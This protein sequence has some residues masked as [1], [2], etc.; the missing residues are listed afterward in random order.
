[1]KAGTRYFFKQ[2]K[3]DIFAAES[4]ESTESTEEHERINVLIEIFPCPL[5]DS[6]AI[7]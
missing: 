3:I 6:V 1:M 4:T 5:V 2:T 7:K